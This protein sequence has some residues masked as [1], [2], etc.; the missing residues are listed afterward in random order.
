MSELTPEQRAE[1]A[2][3]DV[4]NAR[5]R[6]RATATLA[7]YRRRF[8]QHEPLDDVATDLLADLKHLLGPRWPDLLMMAG[9]HVD[10]EAAG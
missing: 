9:V 3:A 4:D 1:D 6:Y 7:Y 5:R 10:A 8:D 2:D